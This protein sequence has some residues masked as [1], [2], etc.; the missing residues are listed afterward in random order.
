MVYEPKLADYF[1]IVG[2]ED[3]THPLDGG[4]ECKF[5]F[6]DALVLFK[7]CRIEAYRTMWSCCPWEIECFGRQETA[8]SD[9]KC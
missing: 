1:V 6:G 2:L 4:A 9:K 3:E 7:F 8:L 5:N